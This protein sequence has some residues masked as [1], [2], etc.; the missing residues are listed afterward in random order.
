M[1]DTTNNS[2]SEMAE[3]DSE[4]HVCFKNDLPPQFKGFYLP[5]TPLSIIAVNA[6][7][8]SGDRNTTI[9]ELLEHHRSGNCGYMAIF[10]KNEKATT[11][12]GC[13]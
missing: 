7:L 1:S 10:D 6:V 5:G 11:G 3:V 2:L 9:N 12:N 4:I 8:S 13:S